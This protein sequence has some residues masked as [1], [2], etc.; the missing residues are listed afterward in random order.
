MCFGIGGGCHRTAPFKPSWWKL[1]LCSESLCSSAPDISPLFEGEEEEL[2]QWYLEQLLQPA[3][4][5]KA[6]CRVQGIALIL[7]AVTQAG[8]SSSLFTQRLIS[9]TPMTF[10]EGILSRKPQAK[11]QVWGCPA[12]SQG[13]WNCAH[14]S[15]SP[16]AAGPEG[17]QCTSQV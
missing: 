11:G 10:E 4:Q 13:V 3:P 16:P 7:D 15:L 9:Y 12:C 5:Q 14:S 6:L 17:S 8:H 2:H 1:C